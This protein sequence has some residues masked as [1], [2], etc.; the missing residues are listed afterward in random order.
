MASTKK[1]YK[2]LRSNPDDG[3]HEWYKLACDMSKAANVTPKLPRICN[4]MRHKSN[5]IAEPVYDGTSND[6]PIAKHYAINLYY[7]FLD[8]LIME[9]EE[10]FTSNLYCC[11]N[12][13]INCPL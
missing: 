4:R 10:Q 3:M 7:P 13:P 9:L 5:A 2:D 11:F 8:H 12:T 6:D 1:F